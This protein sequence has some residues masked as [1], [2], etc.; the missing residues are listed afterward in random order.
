MS[1]IDFVGILHNKTKRDYIE[2]VVSHDKAECA[3]N[4]FEI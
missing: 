2:R 1:Y 4:C 3:K